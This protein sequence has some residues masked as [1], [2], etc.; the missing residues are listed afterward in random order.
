ME[1]RGMN[2][3][4]KALRKLSENTQAHID[5]ERAK[6]ET[7]T[8]KKYEGELSIPELRAQVLKDYFSTKSL[9]IGDGEL[10]VGEKGNEPWAAPTF[11]ELCCHTVED[12]HVMNDR[13]LISFKVKEEDYKYQEDVIIPY[14]E[15][16]SIRKKILDNMTPQWKDC[17][18]AGIVYRVHGAERT[19]TYGRICEDL[20]KGFLDYK[21]D[22]PESTGSTGLPE[23]SGSI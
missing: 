14:W 17:Y 20:R 6:S 13:D 3:R 1:E 15:K 11:P 5:M 23:R 10:I 9:Y 2:A 16:R 19:G 8:Y 21:E 18:E 22:I 12:M 7:E 4:I